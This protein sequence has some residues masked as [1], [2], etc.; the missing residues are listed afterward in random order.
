MVNAVQG[1]GV[2]VEGRG[3][4]REQTT[5][6]QRSHIEG[7]RARVAKRVGAPL[8]VGPLVLSQQVLQPSAG[9]PGLGEPRRQV[10]RPQLRRVERGA[11]VVQDVL[12]SMGV[13]LDRRQLRRG[14]V[15]EPRRVLRQ[16]GRPVRLHGRHHSRN[17]HGDPMGVGQD[18]LD[19]RIFETRIGDGLL[20]QFQRFLFGEL[21]HDQLGLRQDV[22][23]ARGDQDAAVLSWEP[24]IASVLLELR[25]VLH[26][27]EDEQMG[28]ASRSGQGVQHPLGAFFLGLVGVGVAVVIGVERVQPCMVRATQ[29]HDVLV[30]IPIATGVEVGQDRLANA[31]VAECRHGGR[32][33]RVVCEEPPV[34]VCEEP[35]AL[36]EG[37]ASLRR[38]VGAEDE[39]SP[40][41][42]GLMDLLDLGVRL[43]DGDLCPVDRALDIPEQ[44]GLF[45]DRFGQ[46]LEGL[47]RERA[48]DRVAIAREEIGDVRL[49]L[50]HRA[51]D[52]LNARP[53]RL[54][55]VKERLVAKDLVAC[56]FLG[57]R[58][59]HCLEDRLPHGFQ[60]TLRF[61]D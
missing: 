31:S 55:Q 18:L 61:L 11:Q 3:H 48:H 9:E 40:L 27:V 21:V 29:H 20:Q 41:G 25:L 36:D 47:A 46:R 15:P 8:Q 56:D 45:L 60:A 24:S 14:K 34:E 5:V 37:L 23:V 1:K 28:L 54:K 16:V 12:R 33:D 52:A 42:D 35:F 51:F 44:L 26:I 4:G 10:E 49:Q 53:G 22:G 19:V 59:P 30:A 32:R 58:Q 57:I 43:V 50:G 13:T 39:R 6:H 38:Q 2:G 7:G 17:E